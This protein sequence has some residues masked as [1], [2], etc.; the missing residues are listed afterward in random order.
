MVIIGLKVRLE[1]KL[2]NMESGV[3]VWVLAHELLHHHYA[4]VALVSNTEVHLILQGGLQQR[5]VILA[6]TCQ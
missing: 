5:V 2:T 3:N 1:S 6:I 4:G